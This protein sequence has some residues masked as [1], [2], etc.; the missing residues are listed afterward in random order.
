M[1]P[2]YFTQSSCIQ[3]D[4]TEM[5][6]HET[7]RRIWRSAYRAGV[8]FLLQRC[9]YFGEGLGAEVALAAVAYGDGAGFGFFCSDHE[10][11]RNFL[12]LRVADL[13]GQLFVAIIEMDANAMALKCFGDVLG[14]VG[15]FIA[16]RA[17]FDLHGSEPKRKRSGIVLDQ[18]AEEALDRA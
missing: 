1:Q 11:V 12:H 4:P 8:D 3:D 2:A 18:Y 15:H 13:G 6:E 17:D 5:F 14:V 10:H 16:D 9:D 7:F